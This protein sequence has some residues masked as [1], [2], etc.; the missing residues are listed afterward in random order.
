[1]LSSLKQK[2]AT[3]LFDEWTLRA[4]KRYISIIVRFGDLE[5]TLGISPVFGTTDAENLMALIDAK[6]NEFSIDTSKLIRYTADGAQMNH[7]ISRIELFYLP[8]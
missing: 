7:E 5:F 6:L 1:M 8:T 3:I 4:N 2:K